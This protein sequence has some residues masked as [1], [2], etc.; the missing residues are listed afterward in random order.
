[1]GHLRR[2]AADRRPLGVAYPGK[3][4]RAGLIALGIDGSVPPNIARAHHGLP[5]VTVSREA[6]LPTRNPWGGFLGMQASCRALPP[7]RCEDIESRCRPKPIDRANLTPQEQEILDAA[8][9]AS[10][11]KHWAKPWGCAVRRRVQS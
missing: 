5:A 10:C 2:A 1:M 4:R 9:W 3:K 11:F 8:L 7:R 6:V